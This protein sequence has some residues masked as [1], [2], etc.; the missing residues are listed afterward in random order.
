ML[1]SA[2]N[3]NAYT[4][5]FS[6][7][8]TTNKV[9]VWDQSNSYG[10]CVDLTSVYSILTN[11]SDS[12]AATNYVALFQ[13]ASGSSPTPYTDTALTYN[14]S[15][16]TLSATAINTT[17]T[18]SPAWTFK[19]SDCAGAD[20]EI[21]QVT[22]NAVVTTDGAEDGSLSLKVMVNGTETTALTAAASTGTD[23]A[24]TTVTLYGRRNTVSTSSSTY[25]ITTT[26]LYD[27]RFVSTHTSSTVTFALPGQITDA[28]YSGCIYTSTAYVVYLDCHSDDHFYI[29]DSGALSAGQNIYSDGNIGEFICFESIASGVWLITSKSAGWTPGS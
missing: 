8:D 22:A 27:G 20:D 12:S 11:V 1:F 15:T 26:Q 18:A 10:E 5:N 7:C 21:A 6:A 2:S 25:A 9:F 19:D 3:A 24:A 17:A 16:G 28:G 14:A 4:I 29:P 23:T 13:T